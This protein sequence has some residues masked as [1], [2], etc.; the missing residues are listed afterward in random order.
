MEYLFNNIVSYLTLLA[1]VVCCCGIVCFRY[2]T[3]LV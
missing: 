2:I 1:I 3:I